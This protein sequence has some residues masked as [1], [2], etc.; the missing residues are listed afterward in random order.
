[1]NRE[2]HYRQRALELRQQARAEPN[3]STR[4]ELELLALGYDRLAD[5]ARRNARTTVIYEGH[6]DG[7]AR[8]RSRKR[9]AA[10]LQQQQPQPPKPPQ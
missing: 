7:A 8:Q 5:Q 6:L 9:E 4:V 1:M 3:V 10:S 2:E